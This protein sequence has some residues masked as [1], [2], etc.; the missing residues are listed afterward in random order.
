MSTRELQNLTGQKAVPQ[1]KPSS[2]R[3][4]QQRNPP[5]SRGLE[6]ESAPGAGVEVQNSVPRSETEVQLPNMSNP[7][8]STPSTALHMQRTQFCSEPL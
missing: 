3:S 2:I 6:N 8:P 4:R 7:L 5:A 1:K